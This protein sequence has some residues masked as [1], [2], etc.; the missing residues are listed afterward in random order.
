[1]QRPRHRKIFSV[2]VRCLA[3]AIPLLMGINRKHTKALCL[4][5]GFTK[6]FPCVSSRV[7]TSKKRFIVIYR[8]TAVWRMALRSARL[9]QQG[10]SEPEFY[11]AL[12][13]KLKKI[14]RS[15]NFSVQPLISH[16]KKVGYNINATDCM[17][18]CQPNH[19]WQLCFP[20]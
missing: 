16:Y 19:G 15:N 14:V 13:Y 5:N 7:V 3:I 18:G 17:L 8:C 11:G 9:M 12:V 6:H 4:C 2:T 20:L 10:L 1:M